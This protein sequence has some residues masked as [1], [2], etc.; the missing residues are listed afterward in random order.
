[1]K[2]RNKILIL[3]LV[4]GLLLV[5]CKGK[6]NEA[7][8]PDTSQVI[9]WVN[10]EE[11]REKTFNDWYMRTMALTLGIDMTQEIDEQTQSF[12]DAYRLS[13]LASYTAQRVLVQ[14]AEKAGIKVEDSTIDEYIKNLQISYGEDDAGFEEVLRMMGFTR[15]SIRD[16]IG[17]QMMIQGLYEKKTEHINQGEITAREYY[18]QHPSEF[19]TKEKRAVRHILVDTEEEAKEIIKE[20]DGGADFTKL[21]QEKS[22]DT[23]SKDSGGVIGAFDED[24]NYVQE[25]KDATFALAKVGDY[26]KEPVKSA[27]GYHV[28]ILDEITPGGMKAFED[29]EAAIESELI[30]QAKDN[31]FENYYQEVVENAEI[32]YAEGFDPMEAYG[33]SNNDETEENGTNED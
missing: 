16:Y 30:Y 12:I 27:Y 11:I 17:E 22:K 28:I 10:G 13:Y 15:Q 31:Y 9:A 4:L 19:V 26:T 29:V 8:E 14:E 32:K 24:G 6:N 23:G 21:A 3:T 33:K 5:G 2:F 7:S 25:F 18:D 20:L 1:M